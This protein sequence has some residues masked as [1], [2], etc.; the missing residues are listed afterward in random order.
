[1]ILLVK[2]APVHG[3]FANSA[4]PLTRSLQGTKNTQQRIPS[5][6]ATETTS[7]QEK[8]Q[9]DVAL[10]L[11]RKLTTEKAVKT[12]RQQTK[13][14]AATADEITNIKLSGRGIKTIESFDL[15]SLR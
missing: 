10:P 11:I 2:L 13:E 5:R 9:G 14:K 7:L 4:S 8:K 6:M 12:H 3:I 15:P 1:M